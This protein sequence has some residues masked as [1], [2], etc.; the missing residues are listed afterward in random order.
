DPAGAGGLLGAVVRPM[1]G[2]RALAGE[3]GGRIRRPLQAGED[4]FGPGAAARRGL[5]HPQHP[6]LHPADERPA[7]GRLHGCAAR[8]QAQGVP[9]Q[10]RA[11]GRGGGGRT[12]HRARGARR[13]S[14]PA[15]EAPAGGGRQP[16]RRRRALRT[17]Q[18]PAAGRPQRRRQG[19]VR[20]RDRQGARH[21]PAGVAAARDGRDGFRSGHRRRGRFRRPHRCQ[22]ARLRCPLRQGP[23]AD[24][25][26]AL[27][28]GDGRTAG[29]PDA[30]QGLERGPGAQDLH[31]GAGRD[32]AAQAQGGRGADPAGR[33]HGG[34]LPPAAVQRRAEL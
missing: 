2:H 9:R 33:S 23:A 34:D 13:R 12:D 15:R 10:A 27:D 16:G 11:A 22:Q 31:R 29:D 3:T 8:G 4:R 19:G 32:R 20:A 24:R 18:G 17:G 25:P 5:R 6:H 30:R 1:Q 21:P 28:R 14:R 7:G 26:P